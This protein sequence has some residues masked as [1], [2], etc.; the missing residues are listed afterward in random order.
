MRRVVWR[1]DDFAK[2]TRKKQLSS[3]FLLLVIN[4]EAPGFS[5]CI[6]MGRFLEHLPLSLEL[7]VTVACVS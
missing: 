6:D 1:S 4:P 3:R 2:L 5:S 7:Q